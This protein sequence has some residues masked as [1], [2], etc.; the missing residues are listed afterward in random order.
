MNVIRDR[1]RRQKSS[2]FVALLLFE[3]VLIILQL[4]LFVSTLEGL[5]AGEVRMAIPAAIVSL[6]CLGLNTWMLV[7]VE[8]VDHES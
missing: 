8:K 7:G 1:R 5:L 2:V 4:W 6:A 3:L